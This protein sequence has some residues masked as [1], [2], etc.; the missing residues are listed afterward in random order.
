MRSLY[1]V[2]TLAL[3]F[4]VQLAAGTEE[5]AVTTCSNWS[6]RYQKY[7][8]GVCVCTEAN[9]DSVANT[10]TSL[11]AG[12]IGVYR[13]SKAGD[14]LKYEVITINKAGAT[15][16]IEFT[17]NLAQ[18]YQQVIG[19]GGAFTDAAA[20]NTYKLTP[21]LQQKVLDAYFSETGLEYSTGRIPISSSDFSESIY[22]YNPVVDDF[23]M[24]HFSIDVD[25]RR[26]R[27]NWR[28]SSARSD[29]DETDQD[30]CV[31]VGAQ[32]EGVNIWGMTVQNEPGKPII[33]PSVWQSLRMT[34]AEERDFIKKD[35]G[36][37]FKQN[38]PDVKII[39]GDDQK[40]DIE[41][42][43]EPF[44]DA[45]SRQ[46]ISGLGVHWYKNLDFFFFGLGGDFDKLKTFHDKYP[47]LFILA[48]EQ[49]EGYLPSWLGTGAGVKITD[50]NTIWARAENYGRDIIG[51]L[52]N[53]AG[54]WSDWNLVLDTTGG[55]N[56]AKNYVDAP[57]LVDE[58]GGKEFYKQPMYYIMGHF[59]KF[60]PAGSI[61][62]D[63]PKAKDKWSD[64]DR[65]AFI[66]PEKRI[67]LFFFNRRD[68][69]ATATV[70]QPDKNTFTVSLPARSIQTIILP[71]SA[72]GLA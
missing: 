64:I 17:L 9:C 69:D 45:E 66:T 30:V 37:L 40:A 29:V 36:P 21:A 3:S 16:D 27:T 34:G 41:G 46:Y 1:L 26:T 11:K 25:K 68:S 48:T 58:V 31:V 2:S 24:T 4:L 60:L 19:F 10:Y 72:S 28:S 13:S 5:L 47:D 52:N 39:A 32:S 43:M 55:P 59:S 20:I 56:W 70:Q 54:G 61:R 15:V 12:E 51:D 42:R 6:T 35:L 8:E 44:D 62:F 14:R 33:Q 53:F 63:F 23:N 50:P 18:M 57:I 22:S 71:P 67:V 65:T 38:H 7:L 49:C